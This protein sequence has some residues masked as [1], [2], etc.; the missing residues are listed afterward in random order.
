MTSSMSHAAPA[1]RRRP[2]AAAP[3]DVLAFLADCLSDIPY[4]LVSDSGESVD[5]P[6]EMV[7]V[8]GD[9]AR[10][11]SR[12][13]EVAVL[14]RQRAVTTQEAADILGVSRPYVVKLLESGQMPFHHAGTHRRVELQDVLDYKEKRDQVRRDSLRALTQESQSMGMEY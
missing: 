4:K 10:E 13:Y 12:G 1:P 3:A 7:S 9:V 5:L 11:M 6:D 2:Q 8:I 14:S